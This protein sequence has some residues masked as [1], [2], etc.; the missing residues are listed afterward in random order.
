MPMPILLTSP[1]ST[2]VRIY[3]IEGNIGAGKTTLLKR[4]QTAIESDPVLSRKT[5]FLLEPV[6]QWS[7]ICDASG[8]TI[9]SLF[10]KDPA[11][12]AFQFQVMAYSSRVKALEELL[13][14]HPECETVICERSL[15]ADR[16]IFAAMLHADG[17]IDD[18]SYQI[19]ESFIVNTLEKYPLNGIIYMRVD[20]ETASARIQKRARDGEA[21]IEKSY[22]DKCGKYHDN[23]LRFLNFGSVLEINANSDID[24]VGNSW[25]KWIVDYMSH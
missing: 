7:K 8:E 24:V 3:S 13:Q 18:V 22:L 1:K 21:V 4:L 2:A 11:K 20:T 12:W 23:W 19:Y 25:I 15:E 6:D 10:Y 9:L 16:N 17:H 5:Q 14:S